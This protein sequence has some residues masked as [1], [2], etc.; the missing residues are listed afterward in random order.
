MKYCKDCK[1]SKKDWFTEGKYRKCSRPG[2]E[3]DPVTGVPIKP[4]CSI[5]R[6]SFVT[7]DIC[8]PNAKYY[9]IL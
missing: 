8:G 5:E 1:H 9:E 6:M 7:L 4:Y 3:M 2:L